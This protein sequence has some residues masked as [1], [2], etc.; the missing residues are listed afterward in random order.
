MKTKMLALAAPFALSLSL[1]AVVLSGCG[2]SSTCTFSL[3]KPNPFIPGDTDHVDATLGDFKW[4]H[5]LGAAFQVPRSRRCCTAMK[6]ILKGQTPSDPTACKGITEMTETD[7]VDG[8]PCSGKVCN[9]D[10]PGASTLETY[11]IS[12]A[13]CTAM[14]EQDPTRIQD[15]CKG[16]NGYCSKTTLVIGQQKFNMDSGLQ[17]M[18]AAKMLLEMHNAKDS[19][20]EPTKSLTV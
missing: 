3:D 13:C 20:K 1:M 7:I 10:I 4:L 5:P 8:V 15:A 17:H 16:T 19:A 18:T 9:I 6:S 12:D 14:K 2:G 11:G